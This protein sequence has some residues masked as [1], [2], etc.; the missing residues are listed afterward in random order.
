MAG[1]SSRSNDRAV[2]SDNFFEPR[3]LAVIGASSHPDKVGY[4]V[5]ANIIESG[6]EGEILAANP[7]P[8]SSRRRKYCCACRNSRR[9]TPG[10]LKWTSTHSWSTMRATAAP[11]WTSG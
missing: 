9:N 11:V 7:R 6:Y 5:L 3:S 2:I 4:A 10:C 1:R 8:T